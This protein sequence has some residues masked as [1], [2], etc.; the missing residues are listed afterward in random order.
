MFFESSRQ[1]KCKVVASHNDFDQP[2]QVNNY[3]TLCSRASECHYGEKSSA[4]TTA[5]AVPQPAPRKIRS[6]QNQTSVHTSHH[7]FFAHLSTKSSLSRQEPLT[8]QQLKHRSYIE[9][10]FLMKNQKILPL[11]AGNNKLD[12]FKQIQA[13]EET[14]DSS[15]EGDTEDSTDLK[16][17]KPKVRIICALHLS[18]I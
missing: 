17:D 15:S 10:K 2:N 3:M 6:N 8:H 1:Y 4:M 16:Q 13:S 12:S 11:L 7:Q 14:N 5:F 9:N 18:N